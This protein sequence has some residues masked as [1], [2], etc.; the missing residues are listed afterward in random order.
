MIWCRGCAPLLV[1]APL[2]ARCARPK[3][4]C[5]EAAAIC[6]RP[7]DSADH[8]AGEARRRHLHRR[9]LLWIAQGTQRL[10]GAAI[11]FFPKVTVAARHVARCS[12]TRKGHYGQSQSACGARNRR[13][14]ADF[15]NNMGCALTS[16]G[17]AHRGSRRRQSAWRADYRAPDRIEA[18]THLLRCRCDDRRRC[19]ALPRRGRIFFVNRRSRAW[20]QAGSGFPSTNCRHPRARNG[21]PGSS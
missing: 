16:P 9:R 2:I 17:A 21:P 11:A 14:V 6:T 10:G 3:V 15:L 20:R 13:T 18:G 19:A 12:N 4:R 5:P 1:V 7:F 8:G